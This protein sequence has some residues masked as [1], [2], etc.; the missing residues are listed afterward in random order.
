MRAIYRIWNTGSAKSYVGQSSMPYRRIMRHL[1]PG[2]RG[3]STAIQKDMLKYPPDVWEWQVEADEKDYPGMTLD[4]LEVAFVKKW[5]SFK[6]GYNATSEGGV[7][8]S[9]PTK[10]ETYLSLNGETFDRTEMRSRILKAISDYH[11]IVDRGSSRAERRRQREVISESRSLEAK[12]QH[13]KQAWDRW[14]RERKFR[15]SSDTNDKE[16]SNMNF[17]PFGVVVL[18]ILTCVALCSGIAAL[19]AYIVTDSNYVA[20]AAGLAVY[21]GLF[22]GIVWSI[23]PKEARVA[24]VMPIMWSLCFF[25]LGVLLLITTV[26]YAQGTWRTNDAWE[27]LVHMMVV[28]S[29]PTGVL[30]GILGALARARGKSIKQFLSRVYKA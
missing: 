28:L 25:L 11:L 27:R 24:F 7:G 3:G 20:E 23:Q 6:S 8:K 2:A 12:N 17:R 5:D 30:I 15:E 18:K 21:V 1:T 10:S 14:E 26:P 13:V 9:K 22:V 19:I 16:V 4:E 29:I